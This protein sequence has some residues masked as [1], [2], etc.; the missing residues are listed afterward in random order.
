MVRQV[1]SLNFIS[2]YQ[3]H[4]GSD[5]LI[6]DIFLVVNLGKYY[7]SQ[8]NTPLIFYSNLSHLSSETSNF[9]F[10]SL[11]DIVAREMLTV[12]VIYLMDNFTLCSLGKWHLCEIW[13]MLLRKCLIQKEAKLNIQLFQALKFLLCFELKGNS[14]HIHAWIGCCWGSEAKRC[15]WLR[16]R[17]PVSFYVYGGRNFHS[18]RNISVAKHLQTVQ[19]TEEKPAML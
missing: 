19:S 5:L 6:P 3:Y 1:P 9:F 12:P 13:S 2:L 4:A 14:F 18:H 8:G 11:L 16:P 10:K 15:L 17:G 7:R